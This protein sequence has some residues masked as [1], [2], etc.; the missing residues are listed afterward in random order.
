MMM[1]CWQSVMKFLNI[2][3]TCNRNSLS[4]ANIVR[5]APRLINS[6]MVRE[7]ISKMKNGK[8]AGPSGIVSEM[9]KE[10]EEAGADMLTDA[11]NQIIVGVT[12]AEW[13]LSTIV[14]CCKGKGDSSERGDCRGLKLTDQILKTAERIL[15][16]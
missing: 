3:L 16:S 4:Q 15:R 11:V 7:S 2:E 8:D 13:A 1:V 10:A 12:P 9:V 5:R 14:N 6:D